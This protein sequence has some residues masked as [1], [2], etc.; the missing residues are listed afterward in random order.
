[1][2]GWVPRPWFAERPIVERSRDIARVLTR[3]GLGSLVEHTGL[4][5]FAPR[6]MRTPGD[7]PMGRARRLRLA[8][9][10]LGATFTKLGQM[11]ST[12][13]D[14]LPADFVAELSK[15]QDAAPAVPFEDLRRVMEEDLG[16]LE[17][18]FAALDPEP[19]ASASI[20]QV[21]AAMLLDG[22]QVV[23]KVRRPG[24]EVQVERDLEILSRIATWM[25]RHTP[26]GRDYDLMPLVE[27]FAWTLRN[28]LDYRRE[29]RNADRLRQGLAFEPMIRI[30]VVH[31]G[32]SSERVLTLERVHG[33]KVDDLAS[34]D[35]LGISRRNI[36]ELAVRTFMHELLDLGFFHADP[37]PGNYFVQPDGSLAI[38]DF[39]MVGNVNDAVRVRLLRAGLAAI[40]ADAEGLAEELFGLGVAGRGANREAF[41]RDLAHTLQCWTGRSISEL[42]ADT[43]TRELQA[44]VFR[45][46]LQLPGELALLLRVIVMSEG[47][48]LM[49][50]PD[51]HY[52]E[53]TQPIIERH[54][55]E[56]RS[57]KAGALRIGRAAVEA[58]EL[59]IEMPRRTGRILG[60]LERGELE[61]TVHHEGLDHLAPE[62]QRMTNRLALSMVV[63]ASVVAL[64][65]A[66]GAHGVSGVESHLRWLFWLG[67]VF[68]LAFGVWLVWSVW[69][70]GSGRH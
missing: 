34:L 50:D 60:R 25:Q 68:T 19:L 58:A 43:V 26:L 53:F 11:L 65:V 22:T 49:L 57:L 37:H 20:G 3:H 47:L 51:F 8:L 46:K 67:F 17:T 66:L 13:A 63:A 55:K 48:G 27:E 35:E 52:L 70:S 33:L 30:P 39:G 42:S 5:R 29:G 6:W 59:G 16:P 10:E 1:M 38:V 69:R 41:V 2:A 21:H 31:W 28:E 45:H 14:L 24:V 40:E 4:R 61:L 32:H 7:V 36:A 64:G 54:W 15:L 44:L 62:L 18:R 56:R 9:G 23:V 12:R